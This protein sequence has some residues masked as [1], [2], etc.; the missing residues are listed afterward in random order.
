MEKKKESWRIVHQNSIDIPYSID[1]LRTLFWNLLHTDLDDYLVVKDGSM[2]NGVPGKERPYA[3]LN[4]TK[5]NPVVERNGDKSDE[6]A[7][8]MC[9]KTQHI[10]HAL[11]FVDN[12]LWAKGIRGGKELRN[13]L[14]FH[15]SLVYNDDPRTLVWTSTNHSGRNVVHI[16]QCI[17]LTPIP[18]NER[19]TRC[20]MTLRVQPVNVVSKL[21]MA[22]KQVRRK[23][24]NTYDE[25]MDQEEISRV[26]GQ[27]STV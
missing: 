12:P 14:A 26:L 7:A 1:T 23:I 25:Y 5:M 21:L 20:D 8:V 27:Y 6:D 17:L 4:W 11:R 9:M 10:W 18:G 24:T 22:S 2:N 13:G 16:S 19:Y 3:L 15:E